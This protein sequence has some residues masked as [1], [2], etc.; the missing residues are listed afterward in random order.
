M[1]VRRRL[2]RVE[3]GDGIMMN[4]DARNEELQRFVD[5]VDSVIKEMGECDNTGNSLPQRLVDPAWLAFLM[6]CGCPANNTKCTFLKSGE[7]TH[8]DP[9]VYTDGQRCSCSSANF[10]WR[11]PYDKDKTSSSTP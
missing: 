10:G 7:C 1:P 6:S 2:L 4:D 9:K 11:E 5:Q 8:D 3:G